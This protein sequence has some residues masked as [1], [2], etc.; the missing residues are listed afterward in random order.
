M[1]FLSP[2]GSTQNC[3]KTGGFFPVFSSVGGA[4]AAVHILSPMEGRVGIQWRKT[5]KIN[6]FQNE[7]K[8]EPE[9][10]TISEPQNPIS[11]NDK[12][13]LELLKSIKSSST[14][15]EC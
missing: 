2:D 7:R 9:H 15:N 10:K 5:A 14:L 11:D 13:L 1:A 3:M 12:L 6:T 8:E 4:K